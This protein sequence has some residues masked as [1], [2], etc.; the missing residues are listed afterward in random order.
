MPT[1]SGPRS[2]PWSRPA[3]SFLSSCDVADPSGPEPHAVQDECR[4]SRRAALVRAPADYFLSFVS[5]VAAAA[6][7]IGKAFS[8]SCF[9]RRPRLTSSMMFAGL[10]LGGYERGGNS[11][12][13]AANAK[14]SFMV[15]YMEPTSL[16]FQSQ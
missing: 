12:K 10:K 2:R 6:L 3:H 7:S 9:A 8:S 4:A 5:F 13:L 15:P 14:T 11:L 16:R 1:A